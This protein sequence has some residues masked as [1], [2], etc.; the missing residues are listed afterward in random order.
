[1]RVP[2]PDDFGPNIFC[3][4]G[5]ANR[6]LAFFDENAVRLTTKSSICIEFPEST[7]VDVPEGCDNSVGKSFESGENPIC[8]LTENVFEVAVVVIKTKNIL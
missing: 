7:F 5:V 6:G 4:V 1:M 3:G 8:S 2:F